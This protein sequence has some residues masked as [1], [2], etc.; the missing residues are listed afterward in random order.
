MSRYSSAWRLIGL[1]LLGVLR[2]PDL[3]LRAQEGSNVDPNIAP[4]QRLDRGRLT[5]PDMREGSV[6]TNNS[7]PVDPRVDTLLEEW[8]RRTKEIKKLQGQHWRATRDFA[9]GTESWAQGQFYVETP[10]KGRIDVEP[11]TAKMPKTVKRTGPK[12]N[13]VVLTTQRDS[14]KDRW[15][16]DGKEI[17][18]ID[19]DNKT[20][21]V[22]KIPPSQRGENIMDGPLPFLFGMPPERAKARYRFKILKDDEKAYA[23]QVRPNWKQDAVDWVQAE[24]LLDKSTY[25]PTQVQLHTAAGGETIYYFRNLQMNHINIFFW[26]DPFE[27]SLAFYKR[28]VHSAPQN[29]VSAD[30]LSENKMPSLVGLKYDNLKAVIKRFQQRG[31]TV[32]LQRGEHATVENLVYV[33][34]TQQPSKDTPLDT[35]SPIILTL[36]DKLDPD[37]EPRVNRS[38]SDQRTRTVAKPTDQQ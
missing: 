12:G 6:A 20:Y 30:P 38:D 16:C 31:Y 15:I 36:Y 26:S 14:K 25:L 4:A 29:G 9:W 23:V 1:V 21:D 37:A 7:E 2:A 19:D 27:P 5:Q 35:K 10:D 17:K 34:K 22:V 3:S 28:S 32:K 18:A 24:L 11:L 8:S 13:P 33:V